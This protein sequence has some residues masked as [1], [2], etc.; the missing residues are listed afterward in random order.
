[1]ILIV[2][3]VADD[4]ETLRRAVK[5]AG[6]SAH[7]TRTARDAL[8]VLESITP[9]LLVID[10]RMPDIDGMELLRRVRG[11]AET[12]AVPILVYTISD[13]PEDRQ[14]ALDLRQRLHHERDCGLANPAATHPGAVPA[15]VGN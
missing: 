5:G 13:L 4:C 3:D 11:R 1:M 12:S 9:A 14:T 8:Q 7:C 2:D 15:A 10:L 6:Y